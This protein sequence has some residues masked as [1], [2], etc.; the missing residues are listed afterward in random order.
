[1]RMYIVESM[2]DIIKRRWKDK[3]GFRDIKILLECQVYLDVF[4]SRQFQNMIP[5]VLLSQGFERSSFT[6]L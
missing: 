4:V 2:Y 3:N 6:L 1:M 5:L